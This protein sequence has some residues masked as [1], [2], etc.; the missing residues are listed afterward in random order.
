MHPFQILWFL[1]VTL[2]N[3]MSS[4]SVY[5]PNIQKMILAIAILGLKPT[6]HD[7]AIDP[8]RRK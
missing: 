8:K 4:V 5:H 7:N 3:F 1:N 2:T 6:N